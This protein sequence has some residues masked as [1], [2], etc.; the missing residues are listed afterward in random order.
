M[1]NTQAALIAA[2]GFCNKGDHSVRDV[3]DVAVH[4]WDW[5]ESNDAVSG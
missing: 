3:I 2:A 4:F 1:T 5:L